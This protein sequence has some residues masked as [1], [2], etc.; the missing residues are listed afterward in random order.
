MLKKLSFF[1]M[2]AAA[3]LISSCADP[4]KSPILTFDIVGKGAY[5]RL[6]EETPRE[7]DLAN[8][9]SASYSY[10]VE[11]VDL[12]KGALVSTYDLDVTYIDNNPDN[13]DKS[14]GP[15][16]L[17][18]ISSSD[19][20][21]N[22]NGFKQVDV[23]VTLQELLDLFGLSA[24]DLKANDQFYFFTTLTMNDGRT[25]SADNS[26]AAVNGPA[27]QAHFEWVLKATCPL[28]DDI[29]VG[30]YMLTY[31]PPINDGFGESLKE[32]IVTLRTVA[33]SSTQR[34]FDACYL[35]VYGCFDVTVKIDFVCDQVVL[36][37]TDTGVGCG[38][39]IIFNPGAGQPIDIS[40]PNA[41][42]VIEYF[43]ATG[44]CGLGSPARRMVLTKQ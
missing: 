43:E 9:G 25:F 11:L 40:D 1:S 18:S 17:R 3:L 20:T 16:R 44:D 12:E 13:G 33:G 27:F 28:P 37:T 4:D 32:G 6:V 35:E 8:L 41:P 34:E 38:N 36:L 31:D 2:I 22:A 10:A 39:N 26:T 21:T 29:F 24:D 19:F 15:T 5:P 7:L 14:A 30:D 42:I 23:T